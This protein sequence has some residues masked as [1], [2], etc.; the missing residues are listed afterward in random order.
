[1]SVSPLNLEVPEARRKEVHEQINKPP[2]M[3]GGLKRGLPGAKRC[4]CEAAGLNKCQMLNQE[5]VLES[6]GVIFACH[7]NWGTSLAFPGWNI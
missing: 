1:M 3:A 6:V 7:N 4:V 2:S 5:A